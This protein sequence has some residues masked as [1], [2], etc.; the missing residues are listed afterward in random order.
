[1]P[2]HK[3]IWA[4]RWPDRLTIEET[5]SEV[6][7]LLAHMSIEEI[8]VRMKVR[9]RTVENWLRGKTTAPKTLKEIKP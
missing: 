8:G 3:S 2:E 7:R 6:S 4:S 5:R 1:M 9:A